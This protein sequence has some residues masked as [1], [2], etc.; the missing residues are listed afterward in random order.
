MFYLTENSSRVLGVGLSGW[1]IF[2]RLN[3][4]SFPW[5]FQGIFNFFSE[6]AREKNLLWYIFIC[7]YAIYLTFSLSFPGFSWKIQISLSF[8]WDSDNF[9]NSLSF[10]GFPCFPGLWPP[11]S[12]HSHSS[13]NKKHSPMHE[14]EV[15]G[16]CWISYV[17]IC[18]PVWKTY[19][20][21]V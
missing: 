13:H 12:I 16:T 18:V 19:I 9:S 14:S 15:T 11:W 5:D 10:P 21:A 6:H 7:D 2:E 4:L 8:P 3:S 17:Q 20:V 1:H